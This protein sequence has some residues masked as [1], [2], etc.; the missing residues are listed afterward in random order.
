[1]SD[2]ELS[3]LVAQAARNLETLEM[4]ARTSSQQDHLA[5]LELRERLRQLHLAYIRETDVLTQHVLMR[6]MERRTV[7]D[8]RSTDRRDVRRVVPPASTGADPSPARGEA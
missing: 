8:R 1:V 3:A 6:A 5:V 4:L 7:P 2:P